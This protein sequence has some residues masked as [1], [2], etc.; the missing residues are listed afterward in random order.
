MAFFGFKKKRHTRFKPSVRVIFTNAITSKKYCIYI[1]QKSD[2]ELTNNR[3]VFNS[4]YKNIRKTDMLILMI[5][6]LKEVGFYHEF[7]KACKELDIT[8]I[9]LINQYHFN[10]FISYVY[11][12]LYGQ[13]SRLTIA[14]TIKNY[15][16]FIKTANRWSNYRTLWLRVLGIDKPTLHFN[17]KLK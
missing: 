13:Y 11:N 4:I 6:F 12:R 3:E 15:K 7:L 16:E 14:N 1:T 17:K 5:K 2:F 9:A 8:L 10:D